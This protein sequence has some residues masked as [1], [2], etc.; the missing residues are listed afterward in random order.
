MHHCL[1]L[2]FIMACAKCRGRLTPSCLLHAMHRSIVSIVEGQTC[3]FLPLTP[4]LSLSLR[5]SSGA[6]IFCSFCGL[7]RPVVGLGL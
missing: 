5:C 3:S 2:N 4:H 7:L 6:I 1:N